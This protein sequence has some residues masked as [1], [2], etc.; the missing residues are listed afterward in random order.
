M[1]NSWSPLRHASLT[2]LNGVSISSSSVHHSFVA[3]FLCSD[4]FTIMR[5]GNWW[6]VRYAELSF[7]WRF[8]RQTR[9]RVGLWWSPDRWRNRFRFDGNDRDW[10]E[11]VLWL[12][13]WSESNRSFFFSR[14]PRSH[15]KSLNSTMSSTRIQIPGCLIHSHRS[16]D[17]VRRDQSS[18]KPNTESK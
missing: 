7:W 5:F 10:V 8:W 1:H 11:A 13:F 3:W 15:L 16:M 18:A 9:I 12:W 14:T 17:G 6:S 4:L 2:R